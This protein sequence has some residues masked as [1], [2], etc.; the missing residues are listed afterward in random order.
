[1]FHVPNDLRVRTGPLASSDEDGNNG[2]FFLHLG[3]NRFL[4]IMA[5]DGSG[6]DHVSV[7]HPRRT[8][9]WEEMNAVKMMFW[10]P[11]DWVIQYH[12][13]DAMY[14][15]VHEHCL[16]LWRPQWAALPKPPIEL[17]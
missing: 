7:S 11:E 8:P 15:N 4:N 1:M 13:S 16:H 5:S 17:V 14:K 10:G 9:T 3:N 6:W 12:P 2:A